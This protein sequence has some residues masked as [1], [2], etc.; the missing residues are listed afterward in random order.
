MPK[1]LRDDEIKALFEFSDTHG[2][3][4]AYKN[5]EIILTFLIKYDIIKSTDIILKKTM[6]A[7]SLFIVLTVFTS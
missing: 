6:P 2:I 3:I 7:H 5:T 4:I 1:I